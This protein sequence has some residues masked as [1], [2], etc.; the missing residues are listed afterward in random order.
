[1]GSAL[2]GTALLNPWVVIMQNENPSNSEKPKSQPRLAILK[3]R[4]FRYYFGATIFSLIGEHIEG[5]IRSWVVWE[6]TH[7]VFWLSALIF[8]HWVPF[9]LFSLPAGMIA[10]RVNRQ[11]VMFWAEICLSTAAFGMFITTYMGIINEYWLAGLLVIHALPGPLANPCRQLFV[12]DMVGKEHLLAGVSLT[13]SLRHATQSIGKP[14]GG[15]ILATVGPAF[16]FLIDSLLFVPMIITLRF[17]INVEQAE[18]SAERRRPTF[19]Q[20][21]EGIKYVS[22]DRSILATICLGIAPSTFIGNALIIFYLLY[23]EQVF[24]MKE[25]AY[26][27]FLAA[28]GIGALVGVILLVWMGN[29]AWK[30]KL[31]LLGV[32]GYS[33][34]L[35]AFALSRSFPLSLF[36]LFGF[37]ICQVAVTAAATTLMLNSATGDKRGQVM[38]IYNFGSMGLRVLNGPFFW[39]AHTLWVAVLAN[40]VTGIAAAVS[41]GAVMIALIGLGV[42]KFLPGMHRQ[43]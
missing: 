35:I 1:M 34:F 10:D 32:F 36:F 30:G 25:T 15:L 17:I 33:G 5:V 29:I 41:S 39:G 12:H 2:L 11:R 27:L 23:A 42:V 6:I 9:T 24:H 13:S 37:G 43:E 22:K 18:V 26:T 20:F 14:I 21:T 7:S 40:P 3:I 31:L 16:G 19:K 38:G 4:N 28:D 8:V